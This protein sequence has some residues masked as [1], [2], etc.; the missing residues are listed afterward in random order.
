MLPSAIAARCGTVTRDKGTLPVRLD[1]QDAKLLQLCLA[2]RDPT[3]SGGGVKINRFTL[4][5]GCPDKAS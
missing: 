5:P 2:V 4:G 1:D 3:F